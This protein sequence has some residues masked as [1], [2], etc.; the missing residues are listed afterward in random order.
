M[1]DITSHY[2]YMKLANLGLQISQDLSRSVI[3]RRK[4]HFLFKTLSFQ[5]QDEITTKSSSITSSSAADIAIFSIQPSSKRYRID[6]LNSFPSSNSL[7]QNLISRHSNPSTFEPINRSLHLRMNVST[8]SLEVKNEYMKK[9][10]KRFDIPS[11]RMFFFE[12]FMKSS[13]MKKKSMSRLFSA[14]ILSPFYN[15]EN[16]HGIYDSQTLIDSICL[17]NMSSSS[18]MNQ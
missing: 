3:L 12:W 13:T 5:V 16:L 1:M 6:L 4:L 2:D 17:E 7:P 15:M 10:Q 9:K 18:Q 11:H 8:S 14:W